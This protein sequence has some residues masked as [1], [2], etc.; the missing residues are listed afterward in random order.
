M[1]EKKKFFPF[2]VSFLITFVAG[3][4]IWSAFVTPNNSVFDQVLAEANKIGYKFFPASL[5]SNI[6]KTISQP[7]E[8]EQVI[9]PDKSMADLADDGSSDTA[10][11]T[12]VEDEQDKLDDIREELDIINQRMQVLIA[13]QNLNNQLTE[14]DEKVEDKKEDDLKENDLKD[15]EKNGETSVCTGQINI[16][17]ALTEDLEKIIYVGPATAQKIIGARPFYLL[18]DLLKVSGIGE[19]TLQKIIEQGCAYVEPGLAPPVLGGGGGGSAPVIYPKIL[20]SE[21]QIAGIG[22]EKQE[23]VE[24]YNPNNQDVDLTGWYLQKKTSGG[25][26]SYFDKKSLFSGHKILKNSYFL[27]ARDGYFA[28]LADISVDGTLSDNS[29][30]TFYNP[31]DGVSSE[32][33]WSII[34]NGL[35]WCFDFELCSPTP[36]AQNTVFVPPDTTAPV[37]SLIGAPEVTINVGDTY[38]DAGATASDNVDGD[39][40]EGIIIVNP[41]DADM[42]GD[43]IITYN[44]SDAAGNYA[45]EVKREIHVVAVPALSSDATVTSTVYAVSSFSN[46]TGT[47]TNVSFETTK[48]IFLSNLTFAAGAIE[49]AT[50]SSLS[51]LIVSNDTLVVTAQDGTTTATYTISVNPVVVLPPM[52][53]SY[54]FNGVAQNITVNPTT[55]PVQIDIT[56][57]ENIANWVSIKVKNVNDSNIYKIFYPRSYDGTSSC[58]ETWDGKLSRGTLTDGDYNVI[59]HIK[60]T[61]DP[62]TYDLTLTSP[63][64]ITV[65][66]TAPV[67]TLN[68]GSTINLSVGNPYTDEGAITD[69]RSAI[70]ISGTVDTSTIGSYNIIYTATDQAGNEA[71]PVLR[72]V[73]VGA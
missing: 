50:S 54:D 51:D 41:V 65:D 63:H 20:I 23:F 21:V 67:I 47:I 71:V 40:T 7:A 37:I 48:A 11:L 29:S 32:A 73:V 12:V 39:I 15:E 59:I 27:V 70:N 60:N 49:N 10:V 52:I 61:T 55:N 4:F 53:T 31:D 43:Y 18:G 13:E 9:P 1:L 25:N 42:V 17:T 45:A 2:F 69:D 14:E 38:S 30:L 22:D 44:V 3:F 46:A 64:K 5:S 8:A 36:K 26:V 68:G 28:S 19:K 56:A 57:N 62:I 6:A 72:T 58:N 66:T 34:A 24:L 16:N 33:N 35:S